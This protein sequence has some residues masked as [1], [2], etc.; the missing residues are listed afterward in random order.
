MDPAR[1][2]NRDLVWTGLLTHHGNVMY[3]PLYTPDEMTPEQVWEKAAAVESS[4]YAPGDLVN[5]DIVSEPIYIKRHLAGMCV[6]TPF[7][8]FVP[9][10]HHGLAW[11]CDRTGG[12]T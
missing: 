3:S 8:S 9:T 12:F 2:L 11:L 10:C 6:C 5:L 1:S 7:V 4:N